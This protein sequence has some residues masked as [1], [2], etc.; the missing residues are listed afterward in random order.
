MKKSF[1]LIVLTVLFSCTP[2]DTP[3]SSF[4]YWK[5]VFQLT[6]LEKNFLQKHPKTSLY[7]RYFDV[8]L[9]DGQPFPVAPIYFREKKIASNI[10]PVVFI[11]NEVFLSK[12]LHIEGLA[13][14]IV[15]LVQQINTKNHMFNQEIQID[16]DWSLESKDRFMG[17]L[18]VLKRKY[19]KTI[20]ATI[21]LHQIKYFRDTKVPPVDYGVLMFYNM[22]KLQNQE[23]NS[24]YDAKVAE[25]Y[26]PSL[27]KYPLPLKAAFP[28]F[29]WIKHS[30]NNQIVQLISKT[31]AD[32]F[33]NNPNF[34]AKENGFLV[35]QNVLFHS[36]FFK[37]GDQIIPES[38]SES[39]LHEMQE[40]LSK[41]QKDIVASVIYYDF[42]EFNIKKYPNVF[43]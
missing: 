6:P 16:C 24:I 5:T 10:I 18:K 34:E 9:I 23:S 19:D 2:N 27:A 7:V 1:L 15:S 37:E 43:L 38:I 39:D 42:D 17:F 33:K 35:K 26:L 40:L 3:T 8:K 11:K 21:R 36:H 22:G 32:I 4:Y 20:S 14:K 25:Q 28:I 31:N 13:D 41:Y 12:E 30:R 29:S